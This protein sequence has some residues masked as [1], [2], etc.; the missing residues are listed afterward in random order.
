[1]RDGKMAAPDFSV[2]HFSVWP[3]AAKCSVPIVA[4]ALERGMEPLDNSSNFA[5]SGAARCCVRRQISFLA[6]IQHRT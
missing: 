2:T 3:L 1:M 5:R 6:V 4:V